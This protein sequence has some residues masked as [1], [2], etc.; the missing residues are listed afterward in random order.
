M[1]LLYSTFN[2]IIQVYI[3]RD[4]LAPSIMYEYYTLEEDIGPYGREAE[5]PLLSTPLMA[6]WVYGPFLPCSDTCI[7]GTEQHSPVTTIINA[8]YILSWS[9]SIMLC[10]LMLH[11]AVYNIEV[12][13]VYFA[14]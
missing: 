10:S 8:G 5:G 14:H 2:S 6:G 4:D 11:Y 13:P 12:D 3:S 1:Y 9:L 7:T